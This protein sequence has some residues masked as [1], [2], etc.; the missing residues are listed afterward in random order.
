MA[1]RKSAALLGLNQ[2]AS[3]NVL[4]VSEPTVSRV[5][6]NQR[7]LDVSTHEGQCAI[8]PV[9]A[10]LSLDALVGGSAE[11]ARLWFQEPNSGVG[12][13]IPADRVQ[14]VEGPVDVVHY[15]DAMRGKL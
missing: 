9:H 8:L 2:H 15:L 14:T 5:M 6:H 12:G 4:G 1:V 13:Q 11:R 3:A 10:F 7:P